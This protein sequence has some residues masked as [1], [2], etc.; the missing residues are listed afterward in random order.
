MK[1]ALVKR[2]GVVVHRYKNRFVVALDHDG[3]KI[4]ATLAGRVQRH[5]VRV[6]TGDRVAVELSPYDRGLGRVVYRF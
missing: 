1:E 6:V 4:K 3:F 2:E 5:G